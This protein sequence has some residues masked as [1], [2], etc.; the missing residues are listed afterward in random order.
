MSDL[1]AS[2]AD[3]NAIE[4][5]DGSE[6]PLALVQSVYSELTGAQESF[7]R[8]LK[9][10]HIISVNDIE[11]LIQKL[12]QAS[13]QYNVIGAKLLV[14]ILYADNLR[15][16][17]TTF[18][19]FSK[20][21]SGR[22]YPVQSIRVE[23]NF[24]IQEPQAQAR[25]YRIV[26]DLGSRA[27]LRQSAAKEHGIEAALIKLTMRYSGRLLVEHSD[28]IVGKFLLNVLEEWYSTV[29]KSKTS[30]IV[31]FLKRHDRWHAALFRILATVIFFCII[32]NFREAFFSPEFT[33][34]EGLFS[35]FLL[36]IGYAILHQISFR[37][38]TEFDSTIER[39]EPVSAINF[40]KSDED[41]IKNHGKSNTHQRN[42]S[43]LNLSLDFVAALAIA[44]IV[45]LLLPTG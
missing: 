17:I 40:G 18:D 15:L 20:I 23:Y 24:L 39:L 38:G 33:L 41:L 19:E 12:V 44:L 27:A 16:K 31:N 9:D 42:L 21:D 34:N 11:Q 14:S 32:Y 2:E 30:R 37:L 7:S 35:M 26:V 3:A 10:N 25:N 6:A 5:A 29:Q 22:P 8:L 45:K 1:E 28:Y 36:L 4:L 13:K 43:I